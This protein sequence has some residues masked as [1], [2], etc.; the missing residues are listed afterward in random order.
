MNKKRLYRLIERVTPPLIPAARLL[1]R[2][3]GRAGARLVPIVEYTHL[4]LDRDLNKQWAILDTFD[5]YSP[6]H[7]HPQSLASVKKWFEAAGFIN[8]QVKYGPNGVVGR[9]TKGAVS[10]ASAL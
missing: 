8:I 1:R 7:D 2:L 9:G 6:E 3:A 5:M 4:G 10:R